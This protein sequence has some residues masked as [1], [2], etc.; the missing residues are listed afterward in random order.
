[1]SELELYAGC[2]ALT[3]EV[4]H[5]ILLSVAIELI[6]TSDYTVGNPRHTEYIDASNGIYNFVSAY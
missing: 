6:C 5:I 3:K 1:M 4:G 2:D